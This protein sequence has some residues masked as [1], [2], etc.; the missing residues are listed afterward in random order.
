MPARSARRPTRGGDAGA[1]TVDAGKLELRDGGKVHSD[2][3]GAGA[4][5]SVNITADQLLSDRGEISTNS[6]AAGGGEIQLGVDEFIDLRNSEVTTSVQGGTDTKRRQHHHRPRCPG[7]RP[8][9][10][11]G[12][13]Q[14][15]HGHWRQR[16]D[17]GRQHPGPGRRF[18]GAGGTRHQRQRRHSGTRRHDHV[19][20]PRSICRAGSWCSKAG[21]SIRAAARALR[22]AARH[23]RQQLHRRRPR[24]PAAEPGRAAVGRLSRGRLPPCGGGSGAARGGRAWRPAPPCAPRS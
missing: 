16:P 13:C 19:A 3:T 9:Q 14:R 7:D 23:R 12:Q 10:D 15:T 8:Q 11:P 5:G 6:A 21:S 4:A 1:I 24:R 17:R 2:A 20:R 18:R 22:G